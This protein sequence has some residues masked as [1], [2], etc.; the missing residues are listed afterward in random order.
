MIH[1]TLSRHGLMW[2]TTRFP[3]L[4]FIAEGCE[5]ND[6]WDYAIAQPH[7]RPPPWFSLH[8][9]HQ[10]MRGDNIVSGKMSQGRPI[11][12]TR[13]GHAISRQFVCAA[14]EI[15]VALAGIELGHRQP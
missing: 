3:V 11:R 5:R 9:V 12:K 2:N 8:L 7:G 14:I 15:G 4:I 6:R 13:G 10:G 1:A